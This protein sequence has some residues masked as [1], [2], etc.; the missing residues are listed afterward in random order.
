VRQRYTL[1]TLWFQTPDHFVDTFLTTNNTWGNFSMHECDWY[2]VTCNNTAG[3]EDGLQLEK[4]VWGNIS[5]DLA[6]LTDL[7][8]LELSLSGDRMVGTIPSSLGQHLTALRT[9]SFWTNAWTGTIPSSLGTL[10]DLQ[11]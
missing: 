5:D 6:L 9:L 3:L 2:G 11:A 10:T 1:S 4:I 7:T 8:Y